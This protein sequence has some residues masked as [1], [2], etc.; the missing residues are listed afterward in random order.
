MAVTGGARELFRMMIDAPDHTPL[1]GS[2]DSQ[3]GARIPG[4]PQQ[5]G[6]IDITPDTTGVVHPNSGGMSTAAD[7]PRFLPP[8]FRPRT[9]GGR[10]DFPCFAIF[11]SQL[12][13]TLQ[14]RRTSGRHFGVEPASSMPLAAYQGNLCKTR[15]LWRLYDE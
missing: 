11:D 9:L 6:Q 8:H 2:D 15:M 1:C 10:A 3:L 13:P 14:A 4:G 12:G 7:H 5:S